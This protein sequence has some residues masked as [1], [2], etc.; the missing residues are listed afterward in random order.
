MNVAMPAYEKIRDILREEIISGKIPPDTRLNKAEIADR[1]GV[2]PMPVREAL[3]GLKG[4]GLVEGLPHRHYRVV[5]IDI[6]FIRNIFEIRT[7]MEELMTRL[8]LPFITETDIARMIDV[9]TQLSAIVKKGNI[10]TIHSLD[11]AFHRNIYRHCDNPLANE[12][13]ERYRKLILSLRRKHGFGPGRPSDIVEQHQ[14]IIDA[15]SHK[16]ESVMSEMIRK[17][18]KGAMDDLLDSIRSKMG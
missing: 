11:K 3:Q 15:L 17:H 14:H 4:E 10:E 18:R 9:N 13:Y 6:Q 8:A 16:D 12:I 1:F 7:A 5:S 2:S